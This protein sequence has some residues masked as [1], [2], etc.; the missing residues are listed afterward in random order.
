M[1][2]AVARD[3]MLAGYVASLLFGGGT[4]EEC[5]GWKGWLVFWRCSHSI[6]VEGRVIL[7]ACL[8][9]LVKVAANHLLGIEL[10]KGRCC[11]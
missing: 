4:E 3:C 1:A 10:L 2:T 6:R 11:D 9:L 8:G 5:V 7:T